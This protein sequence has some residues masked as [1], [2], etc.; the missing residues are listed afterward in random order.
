VT[1]DRRYR[2]LSCNPAQEAMFGICAA[3]SVGRFIEE[4]LPAEIARQAREDNG[5]CLET[6]TPVIFE[7]TFA[8]PSGIKHFHTTLVPVREPVGRIARLI[9]VNRDITEQKLAQERDRE[10]ER[11]LLQA[12]KLAALGTLVSGIAHEINN[13]NNYIR[14]NGQNLKEMWGEIRPLVD[15]VAAADESLSLRGIPVE[16][17]EDMVDDLLAGI[18]EGSK[19]IE[20][21][22]VNL[23]DFAR[24]D[25]GDLG[26][27]VDVNAV[28]DSAVLIAGNLIR[29]STDLFS[30]RRTEGLPPVRGNYHQIEQIVINLVNNACQA[31][32]S[33]DRTIMVSTS[34]DAGWIVLEVADQG[35]GIP[36]EHLPRLT[37][38]FFTTKRASG[39]SGLG[40]AVS[41]RIVSNH[42]GSLSFRSQPGAGTRATVRLPVPAEPAAEPAAE[43]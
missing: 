34:L 25:A 28:V 7:R 20:K 11:Q 27:Q 39:G 6:G 3:D 38:P 10:H 35:I 30:V 24:G 9:G 43:R 16:T 14:L 23:R 40:L 15:R 33:R 1:G 22:L 31:L 21:L 12:A 32:A 42:G 37:D 29:K 36:R 4:F 19:R 8:F 41:S 18:E 13:P 26:Q 17:A 5:R 2:L